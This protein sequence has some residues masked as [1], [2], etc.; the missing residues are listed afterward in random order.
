MAS[1]SAKIGILVFVMILAGGIGYFAFSTSTSS[2]TEVQITL[3]QGSSYFNPANVTVNFGQVVTFVVFN[4]DNNAH[5]F[6]IKAFNAS[7]GDIPPGRTGRTTFAA[8]QAGN[9]PFYSLLT[10]DDAKGLT[11]INGTLTVK[12]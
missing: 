11:N 10:A 8:N 9:F 7:T 12:G 3:S 2:A 6:A 4:N 5:A 1:K